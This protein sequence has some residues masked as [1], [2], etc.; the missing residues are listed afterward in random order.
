MSRW[1]AIFFDFDGVL[2]DSEPL[3]HACWAEVLAPHGVD[4]DWETY[5]DHCVGLSDRDLV[6]F[7]AARA[8]READ[9]DRLWQEYPRK[10]QLFRQ[11]VQAEP[12]ISPEVIRLLHSLDGY[13]LA[14]VSSTS[15]AELEPVLRRA[16]ILD[17]FQTLV[18]SEDV[19]NFKPHPEPYRLAA[20]R[21]GVHRGL[22]VEDS[23]AGLASGRAAGFDVL[24]I[25][26]AGRMAELLQAKLTA[27]FR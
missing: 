9:A 24:H 14:L 5:R 12:P 6:D 19:A 16:G 11:R 3:H 26:E 7:V 18:C 2:A 21:L 23:E 15:R 22:V 10:Q 20:E 1:E 8:G 17:R 27:R 25:P 13:K 4:L